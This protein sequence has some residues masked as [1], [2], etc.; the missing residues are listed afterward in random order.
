MKR[1][2]T[3]LKT[4]LEKPIEP[5][6]PICDPHHHLWRHNE[7]THWHHTGIN[8]LAKDLLDDINSGHNIVQTVSVEAFPLY[9]LFGPKDMT[10][11]GETELIIADAETI[12]SKTRVAAGIIGY[13]DLTLGDAVKP[14]LEEQISA[15]KNRFRGI[16]VITVWD[17]ESIFKD[18]PSP[19]GVMLTPK[20]REGFASLSKYNLSFDSW[21]FFHQVPEL[22]DLANEFPE[23]PIIVNHAGGFLGIEHYIKEHD[24]VVKQWKKGIAEL[25]KCPNISMKLGGLGMDLWGFGWDKQSTA[26]TSAQ[27]AQTMSPFLLYCIEKFGVHRCMFESNFPVDKESYSYTAIWNA[28]KLI[29]KGFSSDERSALF[30]DTAVKVYRL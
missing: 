2:D 27:L 16:R 8:Y 20:F 7:K 30:H 28:F 23:I 19:R 15:G 18:P 17:D 29:T 9:H 13:A 24:S 3:Q 26:A 4:V 10:P 21:L 12:K 22:V 1:T 14:V 25:A 6:L 5:E 11:V